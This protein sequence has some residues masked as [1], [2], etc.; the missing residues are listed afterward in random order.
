M[1]LKV[2]RNSLL[3]WNEKEIAYLKKW[4]KKKRYSDIARYLGRSTHAVL[5]RAIMLGL[6]KKQMKR[7]SNEEEHFL[8][9]NFRKMTYK[10]IGRYLNRTYGSVKGKVFITKSLRKVKVRKWKPQ[11]KRLLSRLYTKKPVEEIALRLKRTQSSVKHRAIIQKKAAIAAPHYSDKEKEF[12]SKNYL[13]MTNI[14]IGKKLNRTA[15]SIR[16][17]AEQLGLV[18]N[19]EKRKLWEKGNPKQFYSEKE[20]DFIRKN[21]ILLTNEKLAEKLNRTGKGISRIISKL[22]LRRYPQRKKTYNE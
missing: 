3:L 4:H 7:W 13:K 16:K 12:I 11:E 6:R 20:K 15:D 5:A 14:I 10:Q 9:R 22:G 18:G 19:P 8:I 17:V 1:A 2:E 21:Y